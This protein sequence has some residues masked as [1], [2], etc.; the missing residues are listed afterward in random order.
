MKYFLFSLVLVC[1]CLFGYGNNYSN[2]SIQFISSSISQKTVAHDTTK[3]YIFLTFDD[4]PQK[5][6]M[7]VYNVLKTQGVKATFFM[8]GLHAAIKSD[9]KEIVNT[10]KQSYPLTLLANHSY[11]HANDKYFYFYHHPDMALQDFLHAQETLSV[12]HKIIRLPGNSAWVQSNKIKASP[13]V[14][15]VCNKLDSAGYNVIGW[16]VEWDFNHKT[17]N[18]VQ[19]PKQM[20]AIVEN[21]LAKNNVHTKNCVVV[22][23]HDRM[24]RNPNYTDSLYKFIGLLKQHPNYVFETIDHYPNLKPLK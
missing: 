1:S 4:G 13:L 19:T 11:T 18:P 8:V 3:K 20:L 5:G 23:S 2:Q 14:K 24:F 9:G 15:P 22:L 6:T 10:I 7:A 21:A 12:P 16:D 17:A